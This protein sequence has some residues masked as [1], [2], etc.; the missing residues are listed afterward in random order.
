M[1]L[2]EYKC[3]PEG[4][5]FELFESLGEHEKY[6]KKNCPQCGRKRRVE[7]VPSRTGTPILK[8]GKGGFYR[9]STE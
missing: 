3:I 6:N 9:P 5:V 1:P 4:H 7:Q 8:A 2:Y